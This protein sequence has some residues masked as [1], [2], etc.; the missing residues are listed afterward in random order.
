MV[1]SHCPYVRSPDCPDVVIYVGPGV[2][3]LPVVIALTIYPFPVFTIYV[4]TVGRLPRW[5]PVTICYVTVGLLP[6][7]CMPFDLLPAPRI[8]SRLRLI[9][10]SWLRL[11]LRLVDFITTVFGYVVIYVPVPAFAF[12]VYLYIYI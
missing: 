1:D 5:V 10:Y 6:V 11:Q 12:G 7:T 4:L 3:R 2:T 9:C 8:C